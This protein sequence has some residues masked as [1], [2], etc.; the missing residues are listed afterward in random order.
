MIENTLSLQHEL[1]RFER[2]KRPLRGFEGVSL[3]LI[4]NWLK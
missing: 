3:T 2:Y 4:E 1:R